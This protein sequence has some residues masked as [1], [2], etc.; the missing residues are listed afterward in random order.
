MQFA[1]DT[2]ES[3]EFAVELANTAPEASRSGDDEL[4]TPEQLAELLAQY[5]F[6]GRIDGDEAE[7]RDVLRARDQI[8]RVWTLDRD[9]AV[10]EV[11]RMLEEARAVPYLTRH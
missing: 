4:A 11:N 6:S 10:V 3:L 5:P 2:E 9:V 1:H 7:R 8:R